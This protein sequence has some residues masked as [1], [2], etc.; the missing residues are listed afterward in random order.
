MKAAPN[1]DPVERPKP[2]QLNSL[3]VFT[4]TNIVKIKE[5]KTIKMKFNFSRTNDFPPGL[6]IDQFENQWEVI[7]EAKLL[8]IMLTSD[9]RWE[10][11]T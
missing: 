7:S 8:G 1:P 2:K 11:N 3:K 6:L 4:S 10:A 5:K 9:L